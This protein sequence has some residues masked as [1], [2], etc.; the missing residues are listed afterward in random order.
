M[1][2]FNYGG[3]YRRSTELLRIVEQEICKYVFMVLVS[4]LEWWRSQ[5]RV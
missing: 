3:Q 4:F 2:K 5:V 1:R